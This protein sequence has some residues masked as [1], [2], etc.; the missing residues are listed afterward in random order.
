VDV[1]FYEGTINWAQVKAGGYTFAFAKATKGTTITDSYFVSNQINGN[2]AGMVMGAYHFGRPENNSAT[3]E[4]NYFLSVAG[5]YIKACH[6]PP[7][8]DVEDPPRAPVF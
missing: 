5:P 7:A 2:A 6:L 3:A 1:S 4:A 8:L